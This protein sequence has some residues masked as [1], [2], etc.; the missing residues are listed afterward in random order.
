MSSPDTAEMN[1]MVFRKTNAHVGS[2]IPV[3]PATSRMRHLAYG[4]I[5]LN[6]PKPAASFVSSGRETGF[7]VLS[8]EATVKVDDSKTLLEKYDAIYIPRDSSVEVTTSRVDIAEFS[9]DVE[10]RH[11]LKVVRFATIS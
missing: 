1:H 7:I 10:N 11:P 8:G 6:S 3:S 2:H 9:A 5:I 4:R